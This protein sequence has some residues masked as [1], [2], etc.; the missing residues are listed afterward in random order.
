[1]TAI[2]STAAT[3]DAITKA[4]LRRRKADRRWQRLSFG[5]GVGIVAIAVVLS[6]IHPWL[7]LPAPD[8][9]NY[10]AVLA[11]PSWS[12]PFGTDEVGRDVLSRCLAGLSLDLRVAVEV[13]GISVVVGVTVGAI[14]GFVGGVTEALIMRLADVVL[15]FPFMVLVIAIIGVVGTGLSGVYI[16]VPLA[17]WALYARLTRAE[18]LSIRERDF[19]NAAVTLGYSPRRTLIRHALPNV[20]QPA[21]VYSTI[22]VVMNIVLLAS[23][24]YLGLGVQ[25]PTPEI[26]SIISDGQQYIQTAWWL[27]VLPG[28]VLAILGLGFAL[29]G[30]ALAARF[31]QDLVWGK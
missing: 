17:G 28:A 26:G 25:P 14:A 12:H 7:G 4:L 22:D 30:D 15:A 31:G 13:T 5:V 11:G 19:V 16:G 3:A 10:N 9:V 23:L 6:V 1:M 18:M 29:V 2:G 27:T 24:S 21:V 8:A 20:V